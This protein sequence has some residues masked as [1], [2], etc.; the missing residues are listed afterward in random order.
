MQGSRESSTPAVRNFCWIASFSLLLAM[1][2]VSR[3][4]AQDYIPA[5]RAFDPPGC[6]DL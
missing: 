4:S 5:T 6:S 1:V 2:A 3:L